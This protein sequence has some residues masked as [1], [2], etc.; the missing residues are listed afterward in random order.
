[1]SWW[2]KDGINHPLM[3]TETIKRTAKHL[4]ANHASYFNGLLHAVCLSAVETKQT[5][6]LWQ[7]SKKPRRGLFPALPSRRAQCPDPAAA[8]QFALQSRQKKDA[9][10]LLKLCLL[11]PPESMNTLDE[12]TMAV[13]ILCCALV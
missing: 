6:T 3:L 1:M 8:A 7:G 9:Y 12:Q 13:H 11:K 5:I 10:H 2:E 4:G